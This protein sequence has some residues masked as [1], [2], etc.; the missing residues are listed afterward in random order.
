MISPPSGC[1]MQPGADPCPRCI[2]AQLEDATGSLDLRPDAPPGDKRTRQGRL[3]EVDREG[4]IQHATG[5]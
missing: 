3:G 5:P 2:V 4:I 1:L